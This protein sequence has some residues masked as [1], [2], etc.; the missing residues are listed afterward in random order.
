MRA[1][2]QRAERA[3]E[4]GRRRNRDEADHDRRGGADRRDLPFRIMS[5]SDHTDSVAAGAS[6]VVT[7]ASAAAIVGAEARC[8]R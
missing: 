1:E 4:T 6:I 7:K 2:R 8:P 5:M 3:H